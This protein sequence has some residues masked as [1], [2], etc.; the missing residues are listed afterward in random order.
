MTRLRSLS[1]LSLLAAAPAGLAAQQTPPVAPR[2]FPAVRAFADEVVRGGKV[3]GVAIAIGRGDAPPTWIVAGKAAFAADAPSATPDTLWRIYSMTKPITGIAAMI[4]VD[5]GKLKLDQPVSD[6]FPEF[7]NARVLT[8]PLHGTETRPATRAMTVRD[9]M[10]HVSGLDYAIIPNTPA[11]K[12]LEAQGV[13]PIQVNPKTEAQVRPLRPTTLAEFARRAG[14]APLVADPETK[15]SYS[16]GLDVLAAVVEKAS[17]TPF[18]SFVAQRIFRPLGMASTWWQVPAAQAG[19]LASN[20]G[21]QAA[22]DL[23][24]PGTTTPVR[25][26]IVLVD[27]GAHSVFLSPPSF[28]FGGAGLVSTARDYDRF[29]H[30]LQNGGTLGGKRIISESTARL[31][32]SNLMPAGVFLVGAGPIPPGEQFGFGAGGFV[33][34]SAV[35]GFGRGKGTYGW[36]GAAG[37]RA[38]VDP[39]RNVRATM[40]IN[41]L[42]SGEIGNAFDKALARDMAPE[43]TQ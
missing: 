20:Y 12:A 16:M 28:P 1:A 14:K 23:Y 13:E 21:P 41:M 5:Q 26:G 34:L 36:D 38:W 39:V 3:P 22:V 8:D 6:F 17:G 24:W 18:E 29:L 27:D 10:T 42:V 11:R 4:L 40:M 31:A 15:W 2:D 35:D 32:K 43:K 37:S 7:A 33:T 25:P 30:M 9:L 19:R